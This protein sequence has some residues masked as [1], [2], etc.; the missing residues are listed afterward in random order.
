MFRELFQRRQHPIVLTG[1]LLE[2]KPGQVLVLT[3]P[4]ALRPEEREAVIAAIRTRFGST[5]LVFV[6][7][8]GGSLAVEDRQEGRNYAEGSDDER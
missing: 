1:T 4:E 8:G 3:T 7:A 2:P 6:V 5:E